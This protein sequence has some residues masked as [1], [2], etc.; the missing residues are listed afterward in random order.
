MVNR[1]TMKTIVASFLAV[2]LLTALFFSIFPHLFQFEATRQEFGLC[3]HVQ[4]GDLD[5]EMKQS[6][7]LETG[8]RWVRTDWT[9]N[10]T[11]NW[12]LI[13]WAHNSSIKVLGILDHQT[14]N[15]S[16][17]FTLTDWVNE[18]NKT[19]GRYPK[20]DAWEIWNEP[21]I[22]P[23][24]GFMNGEPLNYTQMLSNANQIIKKETNSSVIF[25]GVSTSSSNW[26]EWLRKCYALGAANFCDYQGLH[27]YKDDSND[28]IRDVIRAREITG[29]QI[30]VTEIGCPSWPPWLSPFYT[31]EGQAYY[32]KE[33]FKKLNNIRDICRLIFWYEFIDSRPMDSSSDKENYFGLIRADM[34]KKPSFYVFLSFTSPYDQFFLIISVFLLTLATILIILIKLL[35][36][37]QIW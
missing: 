21:N 30:W 6:L 12:E 7:F 32:L 16:Q 27:T 25:G 17:N 11:R 33:N 36:K 34:T 35:R 9:W 13:S 26:E 29:K 24:F 5:N 10:E 23:Y 18:V 4:N 15:F 1:R 37:H 2:F 8:A 19:V 20:I 14:M 3:A 28:N 22:P 31:E